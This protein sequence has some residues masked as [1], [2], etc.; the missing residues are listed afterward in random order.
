MYD[1]VTEYVREYFNRA[2]NNGSNST[3]FAMMLLQRRLS[4]SIDAI[5]LSLKRRYSR[6]IKLYKQTEAERNKYI[7][8]MKNLETENYLEEGSDIQEKIELQLEKSIDVID[9]KELKKE[10]IV[11]KSLFSRLKILSC[12]LWRKNI[13]S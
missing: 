7:K 5:Y 10:L 2:M 11:L 12:M 1:A 6:L 13:R 3:A 8:K 9:T 4:S